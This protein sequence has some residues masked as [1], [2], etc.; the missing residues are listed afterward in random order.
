[1]IRK[2]ANC[3][4]VFLTLTAVLIALSMMD[5]RSFLVMS[6]PIRQGCDHCLLASEYSLARS[7]AFGIF[8]SICALGCILAFVMDRKRKYLHVHGYL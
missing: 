3:S 5:Y 6:S 2:P 4:P 1:M 8:A 7:T